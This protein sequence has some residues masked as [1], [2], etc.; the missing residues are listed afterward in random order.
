MLIKGTPAHQLNVTFLSLIITDICLVRIG[1]TDD[2]KQYIQNMIKIWIKFRAQ[3]KIPVA[4]SHRTWD[5][6]AAA[7]VVLLVNIC[8]PG[9]TDTDT[10]TPTH[11]YTHRHVHC[12]CHCHCHNSCYVKHFRGLCWKEIRFFY[13]QLTPYLPTK[14]SILL[15]CVYSFWEEIVR[16][17][18]KHRTPTHVCFLDASKTFDTLTHRK[19][20]KLMVERKCPAF[21]IRLLIYCHRNIKMYKMG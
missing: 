16:Q 9:D 11:T 2:S 12:H 18:S 5:F 14:L 6:D 4:F 10:N 15:I 8:K 7:L 19:L 17:Y 1:R 20:F 13:E 3:N 21:V